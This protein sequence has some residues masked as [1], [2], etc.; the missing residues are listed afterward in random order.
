L[1]AQSDGIAHD[2]RRLGC[3]ELF[4]IRRRLEPWLLRR[5]EGGVRFFS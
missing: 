2:R 3:D 4:S 5:A 1:G